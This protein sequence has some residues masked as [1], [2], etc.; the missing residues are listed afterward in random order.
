MVLSA[1]TIVPGCSCATTMAKVMLCR[2][3]LSIRRDYEASFLVNVVDDI[4]L[5]I[6]GTEREV[7]RILQKLGNKLLASLTNLQVEVNLDKTVIMTN[8]DAVSQALLTEWAPM[9]IARKGTHRNLG[10]DATTGK[11]RRLSAARRRPPGGP[12]AKRRSAKFR[13][14]AGRIRAA[15]C[16]LA[17]AASLLQLLGVE[18]LRCDPGACRDCALQVDADR[19]MAYSE[20]GWRPQLC[21]VWQFEAS[22]RGNCICSG[23]LLPNQRGSFRMEPPWV[24]VWV[25]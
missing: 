1:G 10:I 19:S 14:W 6:S 21:G 5:T 16:A 9:G 20:L 7:T 12:K 15:P 24:S 25:F 4:S 17:A 18:G 11:V 22:H 3:L 2:M 8:S 13:G 23:W